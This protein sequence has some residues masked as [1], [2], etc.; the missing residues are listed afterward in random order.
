MEKKTNT[1]SEIEINQ[2]TVHGQPFTKKPFTVHR[3]QFTQKE[4]NE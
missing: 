4:Y 3:Q 2:F 1:M